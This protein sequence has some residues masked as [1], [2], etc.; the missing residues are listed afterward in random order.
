MKSSA[1]HGL[2]QLLTQS[3]FIKVWIIMF[4]VEFV[5]GSLLVTILPVYMGHVLKFSA[6]AIGISFALQYIGDNAFRSPAGWLIDRMGFRKTMTLGMS[7]TLVAVA[8]MAFSK[9]ASLMVTACG[10]LGVGTAPLW[11]CVMRGLTPDSGRNEQFGL[12]MGVIQISSLGGTGAGPIAANFLVGRSYTAVFWILLICVGIVIMLSLKL[13][14]HTG[15]STKKDGHEHEHLTKNI[16]HLFRQIRDHLHISWLLFPALFLQTF[17]IGLITP[18]ITLYVRT[19]LNLS[20]QMYSI[21]MI[22]GGGLTVLGLIPVGKWV[23]RVGTRWFLHAGFLLAAL[24]LG[25]LAAVRSLPLIWTIVICLSISYAFILPT[26]DTMLSHLLPEK[27]RGTVWG[28]F[29]TVQGSG[30]VLGPILSGKLWDRL[31]PS[32]PFWA[33][34]AVMGTLFLI[35]IMLT[36]THKGREM[37]EG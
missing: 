9:N 28:L 2:K 33:S 31:G 23:D 10:L 26:W 24:S 8:V 18:V 22:V 3:L 27:E 15:K 4:L 11:P 25:G 16:Q 7:L 14:S 34:S 19:E 6:F 32:A 5:K 37:A 20:A 36:N 30:M 21:M 17:A 12:A 29:L 35:H 13:P 1:F